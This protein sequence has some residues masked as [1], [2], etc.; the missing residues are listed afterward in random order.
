[1]LNCVQGM[2]GRDHTGVA[3]NDGIAIFRRVCVCVCACAQSK[4]L[5]SDHVPF[6]TN[7]YLSKARPDCTEVKMLKLLE[8]EAP[9]T[10][11]FSLNSLI[12]R[13]L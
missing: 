4:S 3:R 9:Y 2:G 12:T 10:F 11:D 1:M 13:K 5:N 6:L 7:W 8:H